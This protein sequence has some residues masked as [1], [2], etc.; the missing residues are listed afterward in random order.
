MNLNHFE[1]AKL[2]ANFSTVYGA[3]DNFQKP[4]EL[5][6]QSLPILKKIIYLIAQKL[7]NYW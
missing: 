2:L 7:L 1:V 6:K 4:K 3:L 5:F